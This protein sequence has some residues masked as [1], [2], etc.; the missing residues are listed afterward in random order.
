MKDLL[1]LREVNTRLLQ[2]WTKDKRNMMM[3][4]QRRQSPKGKEAK[5]V[6]AIEIVER[7]TPTHVAFKEYPRKLA[8]VVVN[9]DRPYLKP[10]RQLPE[11][12]EMKRLYEDSWSREGSSNPPIPGNGAS[13]LLMNEL[14]SPVTAEDMSERLSKLRK[15]AAAG[16]DDRIQKEHLMK[17]GLPAILAKVYN[18]MI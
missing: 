16:P 12:T 6:T 9:D 4:V 10:A 1:D 8:D 15:K 7:D 17:P 14:F 2:I 13:V 18:F 11:A 3:S 5:I